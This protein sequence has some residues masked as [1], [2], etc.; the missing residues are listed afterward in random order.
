MKISVALS[1]RFLFTNLNEVLTNTVANHQDFKDNDCTSKKL[2]SHLEHLKIR[3]S[4]KAVCLKLHL[5]RK[6]KDKHK[7]RL[8]CFNKIVTADKYGTTINNKAFSQDFFKITSYNKK[9][10]GV[11]LFT[12]YIKRFLQNSIKNM[13]RHDLV[14]C[15]YLCPCDISID[16]FQMLFIQNIY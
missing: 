7:K 3:A 12:L 10:L 11:H 13:E 15:S 4:F 2:A 6:R 8:T 16:N 1:I 5:L 9:T 14:T